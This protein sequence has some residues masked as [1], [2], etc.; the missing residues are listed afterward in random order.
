MQVLGMIIDRMMIVKAPRMTGF[1]STFIARVNSFKAEMG[2]IPD[3]KGV[4]SASRVAGEE[5]SRSFDV[6]RL[7]DSRT[8]LVMRNMGADPDFIRVYGIKLLAGGPLTMR[9]IMPIITSCTMSG[10]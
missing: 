3:V 2:R 1:D 9:I 5:M 7:D 8:H 10:Q 4:T 6:H